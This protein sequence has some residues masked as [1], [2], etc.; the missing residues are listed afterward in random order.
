VIVAPTSTSAMP[1]SFRPE[2]EV[3]GVRTRVMVEQLGAID[4]SRLD[5][6]RGVLSW[7]EL[8]EVDRALGLVL[9]LA[10]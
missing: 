1:A 6:S 7:Q 9:G 2:V 10:G 3:D 5:D 8:A 4:P